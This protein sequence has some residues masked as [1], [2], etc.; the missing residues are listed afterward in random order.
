MSKESVVELLTKGGNDNA[1]RVRYDNLFAKDK[2]VQLAN[3]E[4]FDFTV[5]E[6]NQVLR[7]NGDIFESN[8]NPPKKGIWLKD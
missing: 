4:G 5:E 7:E 2:F 8:G 3:S 6:L 1:F